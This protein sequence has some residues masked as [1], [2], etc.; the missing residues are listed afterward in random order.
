MLYN[1]VLMSILGPIVAVTAALF[2]LPRSIFEG[3][4]AFILDAQQIVSIVMF[5]ITD[6]FI[7]LALVAVRDKTM[8]FL[9]CSKKLMPLRV[10]FGSAYIPLIL[11]IKWLFQPKSYLIGQPTENLTSV[12]HYFSVALLIISSFVPLLYAEYQFYS[13]SSKHG[14]LRELGSE[15]FS[16]IGKV[17]RG[18][19][20]IGIGESESK[21][22]SGS[23]KM[24]F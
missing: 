8:V 21:T 5:A 23:V 2:F 16:Q 17:D 11:V 7:A 13:Q 14:D 20:F 22:D 12:L 9:G 3:E 4:Q 15:N 18:H 6:L 10:N 24:E 1:I 19:K